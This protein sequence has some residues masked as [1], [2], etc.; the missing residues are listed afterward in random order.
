MA[1]YR[2]GQASMDA[3]GYITGYDT[4]WREQLT[5]I[6]P[7]ATIVFLTQP[8]QIAVITEV[9]NDTSIRAITTGGAVVARSNYAILL[10]DSITVDGLAQ[11]VAETLRYY[12]SKETEI[13]DA[14]EFFREFD[15]EGLKDLVN[16]VKQGAESA[17]QSAAAAKASETNSKASETNAKASENAANASKNAAKTS[18]TNAKASETSANTSKTDAQRYRYESENFRNEASAAAANAKESETN[19]SANKAAAAESASAAKTSETNAKASENAA[20]ASKNAAKT[21]ETNAANSA[22]A[23]KTSETNAKTSETN[24]ANSANKAK[25]EADRAVAAAGSSEAQNRVP[26]AGV[27]VN[28]PSGVRD[29]LKRLRDTVRGGFWRVD[30]I[31]QFQAGEMTP[32]AYGPG[33]CGGAADTFFAINVDYKTSRVKVYAGNNATINGSSGNVSAV[34]LARLGSNGDVAIGD[35]GTGASND[36]GARANLQAMHERQASLNTEDLNVLK[37]DKSGFYYQSMSANATP[38]RNYPTNMAGCLLVQRSGANDPKSCVQTYTAYGNGRRWIRWLGNAATGTWSQWYELYNSGSSPT[39][40]GVVAGSSVEAR[41]DGKRA[42]LRTWP[43]DVSVSNSASNKFLQLRDNGELAYDNKLIAYNG[44]EASGTF[45]MRVPSIKVI[46]VNG[47]FRIDGTVST[48]NQPLHVTGYNSAGTRLWFLGKD[49]GTSALFLND[50][51]SSKVE[52]TTDGVV[53]GTKNFAGKAYVQAE[54]LEIDRPSGK[55]FKILN[56]G[57][58]SHPAVFSLWGNGSSRPSVIEWAFDNGPGWLFY[59]Q[60]NT[61][62]SKHLQVNGL[63]NATAFNQASDRDLKDN[64]EEIENATESLRKMSGYTYTL[65]ENGL[66]YAGVIAQEV[67]EAIPEAV[68]GFTQY[69]DL[70]GPTKDGNQLV[71]EERFLSVDYG[72]VTGLLVKVC[73]ESDDRISKLEKEVAELKAAVSALINKPTTLES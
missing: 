46:T 60:L 49:T 62:N 30:D 20:N 59:G 2:A 17:K 44:L 15:L 55:Y 35:G 39:F 11:D 18:E 14:L 22:S 56:D 64:I 54:S 47:G 19:S 9:I 32:F 61:D 34:E 8:L 63:V 51:T 21:S 31:S 73:R 16:Q 50:I 65:K 26:Y 45:A 3:Q 48:N 4:K 25:T 38:E 37:G 6:R 72:A 68:G 43:N 57:N 5:L 23:A 7:G 66:P 58:S 42:V 12:Q 53:L 36:Q 71:G 24:A 70:A 41:G 10:H 27:I 52:L 28:A 1:I 69:T 33:V 40:S 13:A 29:M 67:M